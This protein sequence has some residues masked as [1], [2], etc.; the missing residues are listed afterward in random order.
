[1]DGPARDHG[2]A[3]L[4]PLLPKRRWPGP[5]RDNRARR[6]PKNKKNVVKPL[7]SECSDIRKLNKTNGFCNNCHSKTQ[8]LDENPCFLTKPDFVQFL[9]A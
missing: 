9:N 2:D 8:K 6:P 1:M 4:A 7:A 5:A 3:G